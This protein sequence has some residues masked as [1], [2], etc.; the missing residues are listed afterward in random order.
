MNN[1]F[2]L[3][4]FFNHEIAKFIPHDNILQNQQKRIVNNHFHPDIEILFFQK[5]ATK[6]WI[7]GELISQKD[8][9][10]TVINSMDHHKFIRYPTPYLSGCTIII[11][12][13][14]LKNIYSNIDQCYFLL[15]EKN[16]YYKELE[17]LIIEIFNIYNTQSDDKF[18]FLKVNNLINDIIY[19]LLKYFCIEKAMLMTSKNSN[20]IQNYLQYINAHYKEPLHLYEIAHYFNFSPEH[21]SRIFKKYMNVSFKSYLTKRRLIESEF[22]LINSDKT[23]TQISLESGF[24]DLKTFYQAFKKEYSFTPN[25]Y[26]NI[27]KRN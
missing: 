24:S 20:R 16:F 15:D 1:T 25:E 27:K 26:R 21:F 2:E 4:S 9:S 23:I 19:L 10:I 3:I 5:G 6:L 22:L 12:Y 17:S 8:N 14:Y 11:F 18:L 13:Q 7:N